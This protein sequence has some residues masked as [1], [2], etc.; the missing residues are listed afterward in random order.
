MMPVSPFF[1]RV[2]GS[3]PNREPFRYDELDPALFYNPFQ[4]E[5]RLATSGYLGFYWWNPA[6]SPVLRP[7]LDGFRRPARSRPARR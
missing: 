3:P 1:D 5:G 6:G 4:N 7:S 2:L